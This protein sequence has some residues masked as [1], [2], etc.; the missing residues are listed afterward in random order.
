MTR[1]RVIVY[2]TVR[3]SYEVEADD[4]REAERVAWRSAPTEETDVNEHTT[5]IEEIRT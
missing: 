4:E 5:S 2:A 3:R 1:W